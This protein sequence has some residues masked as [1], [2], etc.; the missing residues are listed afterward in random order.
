MDDS[1]GSLSPE[2]E[3]GGEKKSSNEN[4]EVGQK[5]LSPLRI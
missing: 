3:Q 2:K 1:K 4:K 5:Q